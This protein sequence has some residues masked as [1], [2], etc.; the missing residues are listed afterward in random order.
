M[1]FLD[2]KYKKRG[3]LAALLFHIVLLVLFMLFGLTQPVPLPDDSMEI[4]MDFG[5][6]EQGMGN[7]ESPVVSENPTE[8]TET[9]QTQQEAQNSEASAQDI[10]TQ[11]EETIQ[12]PDAT[13]DKQT[14]DTKESQ[15][16]EKKE[17]SSNLLSALETFKNNPAGGGGGQGNSNTAGNVGNPDGNV[18]KGVIG[19]GMGWELAGRKLVKRPVKPSG[20]QE[21][22]TVVVKIKVGKDGRIRHAQVDLLKSNTMSTRLHQLALK[23]AKTAV[24]DAKTSARVEEIGFITYKF[25]LS[26]R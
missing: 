22:G 8:V 12:V 10:A 7:I 4:A 15:K 26:G 11:E 24:F 9:T 17:V 16:E 19:G 2:T 1:K 20:F 5:F 13:S 18:G 21:E 25:Q 14:S 6:T 23:S 3:A